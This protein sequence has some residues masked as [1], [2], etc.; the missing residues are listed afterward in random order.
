MTKRDC[1]IKEVIKIYNSLSKQKEDFKPLHDNKVGMYACGMT[2]YDYAHIGHGRKYTMDDVLRRTLTYFGYEVTHVQNVTDVGHLVSDADEGGDKMEK[3]A[4]KAGKSVWEVAEFFTHHFYESMDTLNVLR[5]TVVCKATDHIQE[6]IDLIQRLV[7]KG[8]AYDTPEA[9][10]F[11]VHK[12]PHYG[13]MFGQRLDDKEV[14]ARDEVVIG[15]H[16]KHP[17]DFVLWAKRVGH[18]AHHIMHW[19]SPWGDGFPGWHIECSAMSMK[20][21]GE[22]FDI[23]TGGED[24]LSI[25]H[26]NEIAQSEAVTGK[27]L[28]RYWVHHAFLMVDG[29]KMSKSL[30]NIFKVEDVV[31][32]GFDPMALRYLYLNSHYRKPMN[33]TWEALEGASNSFGKLIES[34]RLLITLPSSTTDKD[35]QI[36][37]NNAFKEAI[38]DDLNTS[39]A[40]AVLWETLKSEALTPLDKVLM[41]TD[42]VLGFDAVLGLNLKQYV[43]FEVPEEISEMAQQRWDAKKSKDFTQADLLRKQVE[44]MGYEIVD[45]ADSYKVIKKF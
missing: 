1:I 30:G 41:V 18:H 11:E 7:D 22:S 34:L 26:P 10:Y 39:E 15:S 45:S 3:G 17:A 13:E 5:P 44:E 4:L 33:F 21:L 35:E 20:Y 12:F 36:R 43:S 40:L 37:L 19:N 16:K 28:A 9:V 31:A 24:H 2:V 8:V 42:D 6:Q 14:G 25:H 29:Q 23:H 32:K 27:P 38:G